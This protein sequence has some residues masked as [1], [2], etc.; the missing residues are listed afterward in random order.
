MCIRDSIKTVID[1]F[2]KYSIIK[3]YRGTL[4]VD[5]PLYNPNQEKNEKGTAPGLMRGKKV[6]PMRCV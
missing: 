1:Q 3:V 5:T 6:T 4:S 2:G